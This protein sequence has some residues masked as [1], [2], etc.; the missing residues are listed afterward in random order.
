MIYG[1]AYLGMVLAISA[2]WIFLAVLKKPD[3]IEKPLS[4]LKNKISQKRIRSQERE[5][6]NPK[7]N[8][9]KNRN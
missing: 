8:S 6:L 7:R 3:F 4:E 5:T 1:F 2:G 9:K